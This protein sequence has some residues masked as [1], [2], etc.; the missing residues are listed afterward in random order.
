MSHGPAFAAHLA[1]AK[2]VSPHYN[3]YVPYNRKMAPNFALKSLVICEISRLR[4]PGIIWEQPDTVLK[5]RNS[6]WCLASQ[7][8]IKS[9]IQSQIAG[10]AEGQMSLLFQKPTVF[11]LSLYVCVCVFAKSLQKEW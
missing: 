5:D 6:K 3:Q 7:T 2:A 4:G 9:F 10:G 1:V 8:L 11:F